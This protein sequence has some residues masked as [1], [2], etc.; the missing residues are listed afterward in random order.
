MKE[1]KKNFVT[2]APRNY[3]PRTRRT[4][5]PANNA[6][7]I[8]QNRILRTRSTNINNSRTIDRIARIALTQNT[9][10][11]FENDF[12]NGTRFHDDNSFESLI[13]P[14]G[15]YYSNIN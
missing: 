14:A 8:N 15:C 5:R 7:N 9:S 1:R 11:S 10:N 4:S 6:N 12:F 2:M 13:L 3:R